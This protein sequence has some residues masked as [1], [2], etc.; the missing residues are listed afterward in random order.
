LPDNPGNQIPEPTT[1]VLWS[2]ATVAGVMW[3]RRRIRLA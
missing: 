1:I 2:L 3:T